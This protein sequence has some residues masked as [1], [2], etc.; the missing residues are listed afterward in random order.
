MAFEI[1]W[2]KSATNDFYAIVDYLLKRWGE[3][4]SIHFVRKV[5]SF[6]NLLINNPNI[7]HYELKDI[8]SFVLTRQN[9]VFY[10]I[11]KNQVIILKIFDT[12][13]NPNKRLKF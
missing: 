12:R 8:Y 13:K 4:S 6:S 3:K 7:G 1:K 10:R 11:T 9:T 2:S 5:Y